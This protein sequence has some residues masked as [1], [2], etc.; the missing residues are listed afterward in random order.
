MR[1]WGYEVVPYS[2][3]SEA[4]EYCRSNVTAIDL[5]LTDVVMPKMSGQELS[6]Q[7]TSIREGLKTLFMSGYT[8]ELIAQRGVLTSGQNLITKP[9]DS[10]ELL[11]SVRSMLDAGVAA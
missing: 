7:A 8:D 5:L 1:K 11:G 2:T 9:F 6:E 4:L 10:D 3:G